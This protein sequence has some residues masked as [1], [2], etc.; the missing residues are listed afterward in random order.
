MVIE[1][2]CA[3]VNVIDDTLAAPVV[4]DAAAMISASASLVIC[5]EPLDATSPRILIK[6]SRR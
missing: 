4:P 1:D 6:F 3:S 5:T 2:I